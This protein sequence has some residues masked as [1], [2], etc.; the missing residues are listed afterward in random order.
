MQESVEMV[1]QYKGMTKTQ[2]PIAHTHT[3]THTHTQGTQRGVVWMSG[4]YTW[5]QVSPEQ[6]VVLICFVIRVTV[7][8]TDNN[9]STNSTP[10]R[11]GSKPTLSTVTCDFIFLHYTGIIQAFLYFKQIFYFTSLQKI[12][13]KNAPLE[14]LFIH[15]LH[16]LQIHRTC[17]VI[18]TH[19]W[20]WTLSSLLLKCKVKSKM[21]DCKHP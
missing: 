3:H 17:I 5:P 6:R 13:F 19:V 2:P 21:V 7:C 11:W 12:L 1:K 8:I 15:I 9:R 4:G 14:S 10:K 20:H 16:M 18:G